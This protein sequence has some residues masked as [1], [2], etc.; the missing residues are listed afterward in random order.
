LMAPAGT[1]QPI[2]D[3]LAALMAKMAK[4]DSIQKRMA[5]VGSNSVANSPR[6]FTKMLQEES[7][8]WGKALKEIGL[9]N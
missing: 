9:R 7:A 1:P 5:L 6:D 2:V 8:Q 3:R 4:D